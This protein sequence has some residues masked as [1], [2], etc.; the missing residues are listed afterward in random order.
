MS[1]S[2]AKTY[3]SGA[4]GMSHPAPA[5]TKPASKVDILMSDFEDVFSGENKKPSAPEA[6][7]EVPVA[8]TVHSSSI[9]LSIQRLSTK[10][11]ADS[12]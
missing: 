12:F 10:Q 9:G 4:S 1:F 8:Q 7:V 11:S 3:D 2:I 6:P 5:P